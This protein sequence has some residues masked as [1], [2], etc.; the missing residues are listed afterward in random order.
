MR[1]KPY[2]VRLGIV[3]GI[4]LLFVVLFNEVAFIL[5]KDQNDRAPETIEIVIPPGTS[6]KLEEGVEVVSLPS[7]MVFVL[8]DTLTVRNED[9][10]DHQLGPIWVPPGTNGSLVLNRADKLAYSCSFQNSRYLDLDVREPT[11]INTR[12]IGIGVAAPTLAALLF[13]YSIAIWPVK[14][15]IS[16]KTNDE[17]AVGEESQTLAG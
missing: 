15:K 14:K 9:S 11:T 16:K 6:Q 13:V 8:G 1:L 12:L 5:Q 10:T 2:L 7:D 3:L 4:S 17:T